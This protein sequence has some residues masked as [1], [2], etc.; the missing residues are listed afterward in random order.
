MR[1]YT[2]RTKST[3]SKTYTEYLADRNKLEAKGYQL[4]TV[5]SKD[6]FENLYSTLKEARKA[7]ELKSQPY[8]ELL[9]R[10]RYLASNKQVKVLAK[11]AS[12]LYGK[13]WTQQM[14]YRADPLIIA[15]IGAYINKTKSSGIYG[16]DYE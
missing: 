4:N 11:A 13:K 9:R 3:A 14:I 16:G 6:Q 12:I 7:G 5:M 1:K 15:E 10:E 2:K 8:Q